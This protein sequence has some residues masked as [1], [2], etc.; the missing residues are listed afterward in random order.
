[1][2]HKQNIEDLRLKYRGKLKKYQQKVE[3][4]TKKNEDLY[5]HL[6]GIKNAGEENTK[7]QEII[8]S[9]KQEIQEIEANWTKKYKDLE[10][11][12]QKELAECKSRNDVKIKQLESEYQVF[13]QN[14][15]AEVQKMAKEIAEHRESEARHQYENKLTELS[16]DYIMKSEHDMILATETDN[17]KAAHTKAIQAL[18]NEFGKEVSHK[19]QHAKKQEQDEYSVILHELQD[20]RKGMEI[21][22]GRLNDENKFLLNK[23]TEQSKLIKQLREEIEANKTQAK[24]TF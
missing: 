8:K 7:F 13:M 11:N 21:E 6:L 22:I 4:L 18:Y 10:S 20:R 9:L 1:M 24:V 17:L 19:I 2:T 14:K 15:L 23:K 3:E 5:A 16:R 12:S